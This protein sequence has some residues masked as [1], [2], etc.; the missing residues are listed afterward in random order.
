MVVIAH[1]AGLVMLAQLAT[2]PVIVPE[3]TTITLAL[4]PAEPTLQAVAPAPIEPPAPPQPKIEK[5]EPTPQPPKVV[6][7]PAPKPQPKAQPKPTPTP[8]LTESP[9]ALTQA[10]PAPAPTAPAPAEQP[11]TDAPAPPAPSAPAPTAAAAAPI[12]AARFDAA[13]LNNPAPAYPMLSRRLREEGQVMLRVLV[14]P[15]GRPIR[16]ELRTS[17]GSDRLDGAAEE[18]VSRWR[19][20]PARQGD[21]AVEAWVLVPIVFTLKGN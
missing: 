11:V 3:L 13:Y 10:E 16:I 18:A 2:R 6:P 19:F 8:K 12:T 7:T 9:R 17:S 4:I 21:T 14:S 1:L 20:V 5:P 15:D